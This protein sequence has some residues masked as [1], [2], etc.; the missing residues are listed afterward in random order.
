MTAHPDTT[1]RAGR[2]PRVAAALIRMYPRPWRD[3]YGDEIHDLLAAA[4]LTALIVLD[5]VHGA[6]DAHVNLSDL[7]PEWSG[8]RIRLRAAA[9]ATFAAWVTFCF[10][11]AEVGLTTNDP[12]FAYAQDA[13]PLIGRLREVATAALVVSVVVVACAALPLAVITAWQAFR[14]RDRAAR[15]LFAALPA[16]LAI[17]TGYTA[18]LLQLP[19]QPVHSVGNVVMTVSWLLLGWAVVAV[20]GVGAATALMRRTEFPPALLRL[21][22]RATAA[23]AAAMLVGLLAGAAYGLGIW[24]QTPSLFWSSNGVLATPLPLTWAALLFVAVAATAAA[25]RAALRGIRA[26]RTM[27]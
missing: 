19:D 24:Y 14:R 11:A 18:L 16:G 5:V 2:H 7:V 13:H 17:F 20:G 8:V 26:L 9:A 22:G 25:I 12:R 27:V 4:P 10:A 3:R 6:L 21:A 23:A 15:A 1:R